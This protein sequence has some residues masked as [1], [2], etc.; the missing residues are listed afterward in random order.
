MV[1]LKKYQTKCVKKMREFFYA[2]INEPTT[3]IIDSCTGSGKTIMVVGFLRDVENVDHR[4]LWFYIAPYVLHKQ[5]KTSLS[6]GLDD[7]SYKLKEPFEIF[8][9]QVE[10]NTIIFVNWASMNRKEFSNVFT[11][12]NEDGNSLI[13]IVEWARNNGYKIGL[14]VDEAHRNI[15]SEKSQYLLAIIKPDVS[16]YVSASPDYKM[17]HADHHKVQRKEV[18]ADGM[19]KIK[20]RI[21]FIPDDI[22]DNV[23]AME[24]VLQSACEKRRLL[25]AQYEEA[26]SNVNPLLGIQLP[27]ESKSDNGAVESLKNAIIEY[28]INKE[29]ERP[30]SIVRWFSDDGFG[31]EKDKEDFSRNNDPRTI[32]LFKQACAEGWDCP[33]AQVLVIFRESKSPTLPGQVLGRFA[34][35]PEQTHYDIDD[36]NHAYVYTDAPQNTIFINNDFSIDGNDIETISFSAKK[37]KDCPVLGIP[38]NYHKR[39]KPTELRVGT[40]FPYLDRVFSDKSVCSSLTLDENVK[41]EIFL[42]QEIDLDVDSMAEIILD[43]SVKNLNTDAARISIAFDQSCRK[44]TGDYSTVESAKAIKAAIKNCM[45][46]HL[47]LDKES[48]YKIEP[49]ALNNMEVLSE[50]VEAAKEAYSKET[51][52]SPNGGGI[53][54]NPCWNIPDRRDYTDK[55]EKV[56]AYKKYAMSPCVLFRGRS[57][58]ERTC[59]EYLDEND[60]VVWWYKNG[61]NGSEHL[62]IKYTQTDTSEERVFF[63]DW[64]IWCNNGKTYILDTKDDN[65]PNAKVKAVELY[66]YCRKLRAEGKE[67]YSGIIKQVDDVWYINSGEHYAPYSPSDKNWTELEL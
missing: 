10:P 26:G 32:L 53:L 30:E 65:D 36:L 35:M 34:R 5:G 46:K 61:D 59:E 62:G 9:D 19:V 22:E 15:S 7:T 14:I 13:Q 41:T 48:V 1:R 3:W 63:P 33:R 21:N 51:A 6:R 67:I 38:S 25:K 28:L 50:A 54:E 24:Y 43:G 64:I 29:G 16:Y 45:I 60:N 27:N 42:E 20:C 8:S 39:S 66:I 57:G 47:S 49:Y 4:I 37:K 2:S 31:D 18:V 58:P 17:E 56:K 23:T 12:P 11:K 40:F 44:L 55:S 52:G